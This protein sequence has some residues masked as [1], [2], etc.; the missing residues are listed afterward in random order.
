MP[1]MNGLEATAR[2]RQLGGPYASLPIIALTADAV[3]GIRERVLAAGMNDLLTKPYTPGDLQGIIGRHLRVGE[4][5]TGSIA[6]PGTGR[7]TSPAGRVGKIDQLWGDDRRAAAAMIAS[8]RQGLEEL[9]GQA[10]G[11]LRAGDAAQLG[12]AAHK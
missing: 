5:A 8:A 4:N 3:A 6:G 1:V 2:I 11:A 12:F 9:S 10:V 7:G